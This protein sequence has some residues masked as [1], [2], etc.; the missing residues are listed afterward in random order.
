LKTIYIHIGTFKTGSTSIQRFLKENRAALESRRVYVP[1]TQLLAHHPLPLSL[2]KKYSDWRAGWREFE[3]DPDD[4]WDKFLDEVSKTECETIL[5]SSESFCDLVN[6]NCR[7]SSNVFGEYLKNK[8][9]EYDVKIICYLRSIEPY[10]KSIYQESIKITSRT[11]SML[12]EVD[13][14]SQ[15]DSIHLKPTIYLDFY[16]SLFGREN[17]IVKEYARKKM[18]GGDSVEDIL[19][20]LG[21]ADLYQKEAAIH[22]NPSLSIESIKLK[23]ALNACGLDSYEYNQEMVRLINLAKDISED[24]SFE[25]SIPGHI[26][27]EIESEQNVI[28]QRY[29]LK[30]TSEEVGELGDVAENKLSAYD[31]LVISL[32]SKIIS[33]N[34]I[35]LTKGV[36]DHQS[37]GGRIRMWIESTVRRVGLSK[38]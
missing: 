13:E 24:T 25:D 14:L 33:Q 37:F 17:L 32:L 2:I 20:I 8:L 30:F 9:Q 31:L 34:E 7:E 38:R 22:S 12:E 6:E 10:I 3:G 16:S 15:R 4:V 18:K 36:K 28:E 29:G 11:I 5:V 27:R 23:R 21:C 35:L 19:D 1:T 26:V